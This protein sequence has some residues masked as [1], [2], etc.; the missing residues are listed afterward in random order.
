MATEAYSLRIGATLGGAWVENVLHYLVDNDTDLIN[1]SMAARLCEAWDS[2]VKTAW[3]GTLPSAYV[4]QW[5]EA[6]R[7]SVGGGRSWW[8]E[9]P[10]SSTFGSLG[11]TTGGLQTAPIIKLYPG[12]GTDTQGRVYMPGISEA[13][14][15]NNE[16]LS[17]YRTAVDTLIAA[18]DSISDSG[19]TFQLAIRSPKLG[20]T[21]PVVEA[22]LGPIIG[23]IGRRRIPH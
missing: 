18:W 16:I 12:L 2:T 15:V 11:S 17:T 5:I 22:A 21:V 1:W 14:L 6:R 23:N 10:N 4:L 3:L 19:S 8:I 7:S 13:Q 9:Y 20:T